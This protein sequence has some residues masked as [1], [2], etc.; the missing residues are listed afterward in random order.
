MH[1]WVGVIFVCMKRRIRRKNKEKNWTFGL[2]Y[3]WHNLLQIW[4]V[5]SH[6]NIKA[7]PEMGHT[8]GPRDFSKSLLFQLSSTLTFLVLGMVGEGC[9]SSPRKNFK[10]PPT[11]GGHFHSKF[12][13]LRIEDHEYMKIV[14][15]SFLLIYSLPFARARVSWATHYT[16]LGPHYTLLCV[17]FDW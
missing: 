15:L 16:T 4:N 8:D 14:I 11:I 12:S 2:S 9:P 5:A 7:S 10:K 17:F 3:L 13:V 1:F 6:H